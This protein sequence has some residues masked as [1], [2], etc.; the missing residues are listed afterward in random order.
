MINEQSMSLKNDNI[1]YSYDTR[2]N[3]D[4]VK[5]KIED[6]HCEEVCNTFILYI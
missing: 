6:Y 5:T 4:E 2:I 1:L 3:F